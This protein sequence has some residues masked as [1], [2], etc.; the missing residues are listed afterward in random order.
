M[1][2]KKPGE[3]G[4]DGSE[5]DCTLGKINSLECGGRECPDTRPQADFSY[6]AIMRTEVRKEMRYVRMHTLGMPA[7]TPQTASDELVVVLFVIFCKPPSKL[8]VV[9][10]DFEEKGGGDET[11]GSVITEAKVGMN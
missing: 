5:C 2:K 10:D 7:D 4:T 1:A 8:L 3:E 9:S 11:E 6:I